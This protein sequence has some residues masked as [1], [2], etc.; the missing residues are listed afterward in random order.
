M[1]AGE[2]YNNGVNTTVEGVK[3][4]V[5]DVITII[6][7]IAIIAASLHVFGFAKLNEL[8]DLSTFLMDWLPYF[9]AA[10]MLNTNLYQKG[11]HV[12]KSV[13]TYIQAVAAYSATANKLT[14]K[15]LE[16]L[17][18]FCDDYNANALRRIQTEILKTEGISYE[19]FDTDS[20][21]DGVTRKALK[22]L[23]KKEL[24]E[25]CGV[26]IR[27]VVC[28]AKNVKLKGINVNILLSS[29]DI[30]D[31]TNI[32]K[33]ESQLSK[34]AAMASTFTYLFS[35]CLMSFIII[36]D[37][38]N[39]GW[40]NL[41]VVIFKVAFLLGK[42][43]LSYFKGYRAATVNLVAHLAR[44]TDILKEFGVWESNLDVDYIEK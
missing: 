30:K 9:A 39:W 32:G 25:L 36:N 18:D 20:V 4:Y 33:T 26:N 15:Q 42:T 14:G 24:D 40:A 13:V 3:K 2:I 34:S 28:K 27:K 44:K 38:S 6:I 11:L 22:S 19:R 10:I 23:S 21:K 37:L 1:S 12:G 7:L 16:R 31:P 35:T 5:Y 17:Q 8:D 43:L 41:I 29:L